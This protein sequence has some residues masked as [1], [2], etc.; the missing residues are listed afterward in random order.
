MKQAKKVKKAAKKPA[1][2][3]AKPVK[4]VKGKKPAKG[5]GTPPGAFPAHFTTPGGCEFDITAKAITVREGLREVIFKPDAACILA[6]DLVEVDGVKLPEAVPAGTA[7]L[8][9]G[10]V[11]RLVPHEYGEIIAAIA[12]A[13]REA[14]AAKKAAKV[15]GGAK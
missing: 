15:E 12:E 11:V 4:G 2:R 7:V 13:K 14:V 10:D 5:A 9:R 1:K 8:T 3:A 6:Q